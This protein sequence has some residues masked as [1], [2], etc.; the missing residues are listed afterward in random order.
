[1]TWSKMSSSIVGRS[2][3]L[4]GL[5]RAFVARPPFT[6]AEALDTGPSSAATS[7]A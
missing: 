7:H 6:E 1:M 5:V 4:S 2:L 3:D